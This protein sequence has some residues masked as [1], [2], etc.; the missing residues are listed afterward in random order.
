MELVR[1]S[2]GSEGSLWEEGPKVAVLFAP[3]KKK[4]VKELLSSCSFRI[5]CCTAEFLVSDP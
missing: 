5:L 1:R 2:D 4:F 3:R